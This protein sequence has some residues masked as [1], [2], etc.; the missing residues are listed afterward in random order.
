MTAEIHTARDLAPHRLDGSSQS[1][2]VSFR[3][4]AWRRSQRPQLTE[5]KITTKHGEARCAKSFG[6]TDKQRCSAIRS[7][8]VSQDQAIAAACCGLVQESANGYC[9]R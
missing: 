9:G 2:L 3:A 5:G 4:S 1:L 7:C 6:E 8:A